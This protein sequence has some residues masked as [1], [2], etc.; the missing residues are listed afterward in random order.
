MVPG[1]TVYVD[2]LFALNALLDALMLLAGA[3]LGGGQL[4]FARI[5]AAA[6]LGGA[7]AVGSILPGCGFLRSF[8]SKAAVLVLMALLAYGADRRAARQ[9]ALFLAASLAF[10]GLALV[11]AQL[12][13]TGLLILGGGAYYPVSGLSLLLM[14][15]AAYLASRLVFARAGEH[16]GGLVAMQVRLNGRTAAVRA[17]RDTG[18]ALRDPITNERVLVAGWELLQTLLPEAGLR[19]QDF[20]DPPRLLERLARQYPALRFRLVPYRAVG[21]AHGMLVTVRC[22]ASRKGKEEKAALLAFSPTPV[23][24]GGCFEMLTGG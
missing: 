7:Y 14:A 5:A 18:N 19:A 17:L 8:G 15:C 20:D 6:F 24:D 21:T 22:T 1:L 3:R 16:A 23:S 10:A 11:C 13:G 12:F 4:R 2:V 9:G